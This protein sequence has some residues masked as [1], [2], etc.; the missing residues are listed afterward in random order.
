MMKSKKSKKEYSVEELYNPQFDLSRD[1]VAYGRQSSKDQMVKNVQSHISQTIML[2]AYTKELGYRDDGT[3]GKVTLF[4]ENQVIDAEG[5]VSIKNASGTWSIDRRP[6]LKTICDLIESGKIGVVVAEFVD[7]LFR[8]EDRIDSNVFIKICKE[9]DCYVHISSKRM[10]YN[11]ANP[12]HAELFRM[13]VQMA[14]AYIENHVRG[15]MLR[16]RSQAARSGLWAGIGYIPVGFIVDRKEG[17]PTSGK[18]IPYASHAEIQ[19]ELYLRLIEL[20]Y[21]LDLLYDELRRKPYVFPDFEP[22]V[23]KEIV[24]RFGLR[25]AK[26]GTGYTISKAGLEYMFCNVTNIGIYNREGVLIHDNHT[27]TVNKEIF[28]L[29]YDRFRDH[30]PDGTPTGRL[31]IVRYSQKSTTEP[32]RKPL[33]KPVSQN[34]GEVV[35]FSSGYYMLRVKR[36]YGLECPLAVAADQLEGVVVERLFQRIREVNIGDLKDMRLK[37]MT[38][39]EK[40]IKEIDREVETINE[41]IENL[42]ANLAKITMHLVVLQIEEK[43]GK[44]LERKNGLIAEKETIVETSDEGLRTLE[45]ELQDLE[46]LWPYKPFD[47]KQNIL[48]MLIKRVVLTYCSPRFFRVTV[49]WSHKEWGTESCYYDR[50]FTGGRQW[51]EE[52]RTVLKLHYPTEGQV[53]LMKIL[54]ARS[55][56]SIHHEAEK[57]NLKRQYQRGTRGEISITYLDLQFL[58]QEHLR[59]S[60]FHCCNHTKW[61]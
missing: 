18:F 14:A 38:E 47:L 5:N 54:P 49:E 20:G 36:L 35:R 6:G 33:L 7:R 16:R 19:S 60:D 10:T 28:W 30:R 22:W 50:E 27:G 37:K 17:S 44:L 51:T 52:E 59:V 23:D 12:S 32:T 31:K 43:L 2:L 40:R 26:C 55:W 56:K 53:D 29:V 61:Y 21:N 11:F 15:T 9:N 57:L 25:Q 48:S 42:T 34:K 1:A 4:V 46:Y 39:R 58:E 13:E 3:T 24:T 45:E 8:D 41:E